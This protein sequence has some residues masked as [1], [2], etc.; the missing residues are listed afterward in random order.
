MAAPLL[1]SVDAV[2]TPPPPL[3]G[4]AV[5]PPSSDDLV[6]VHGSPTTYL[7]AAGAGFASPLSSGL[8]PVA[9]PATLLHRRPDCA[10]A[11]PGELSSS[12]RMPRRD[13]LFPPHSSGC[14]RLLSSPLL[15][16]AAAPPDLF[17]GAVSAQRNP[18]TS[19]PSPRLRSAAGPA[20]L[21]HRPHG[22]R[23]RPSLVADKAAFPPLGAG[24]RP[25]RQASRPVQPSSSRR[26]PTPCPR[27][28]S[29]T[30]T[31]QPFSVAGVDTS[32]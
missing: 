21:R 13:D 1:V 8:G 14:Q 29:T 28:H 20:P 3:L 26:Q 16:G 12:P 9:P 7:P 27:R 10:A 4:R 25:A 22:S 19:A 6:V 30:P 31:F 23:C 32:C 15:V 2:P 5:V 17:P 11:F 18:T 24:A